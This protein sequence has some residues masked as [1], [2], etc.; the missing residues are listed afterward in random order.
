M[1]IKTAL[2]EEKVRPFSLPRFL[3]INTLN[4]AFLIALFWAVSTLVASW[5]GVPNRFWEAQSA[6]VWWKYLIV[7]G[8]VKL[9][10]TSLVEYLFHIFVLHIFV[11][12]FLYPLYLAHHLIHHL[13]TA[14]KKKRTEKGKVISFLVENE[15]PITKPEQHE[16]SFFPWYA[17]LVFALPVTVYL[18][19]LQW[20]MPTFPWFFGGYFTLF[21][22]LTLYEGYHSIE[23][24]SFER[25]SPRFDH[26]R[27]GRFW[28][29]VYGFHL[30]HH[31]V[32]MCNMAI[33]GFFLLPIWDWIFGTYVRMTSLY[34]TN[35]EWRS[36]D[37]TRPNPRWPL[38][39]LIRWAKKIEHRNFARMARKKREAQEVAVGV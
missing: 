20:M 36:E 38:S 14:I 25:W 35:G 3:V 8:V 26:P 15:Y 29:K 7:I 32:P 5:L 27:W 24:W 21:L 28:E 13:I 12:P 39:L 10:M 4:F 23:H 16:A 11:V 9:T 22:G 6:S 19:L 34:S 18:V 31:A 37:F 17:M 1:H 30:R 33:S 2:D